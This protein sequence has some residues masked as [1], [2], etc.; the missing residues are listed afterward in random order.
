MTDTSW[1]R[2]REIAESALSLAPEE[3]DAFLSRSCGD[4]GE[5]RARVASLLVLDREAGEF[6]EAPAFEDLEPELLEALHE[7]PL[8]IGSE[9]ASYRI[10]NTLGR[11]G[12]GAVFLAEPTHGQL[13][14]RVAIKVLRS[15]FVSSGGYRR[16]LAERQILAR[17]QHPNIARLYGGGT[18][19]AGYP[20]LVMEYVD[21]S[22]IDE[23]CRRHRL[24]LEA[25]L[26]LFATLCSA[27][28]HAHRHFVVHRDLKPSNILVTKQG[29]LKLLDFGIAKPI[30]PGGDGDHYQT[31]TGNLPMTVP[32]A[33]PE[34]IRG[35]AIT[36]A[37]DVHGLGV[38]LYQLLTG[39]LPYAV[40]GMPHEIAQAV[41]SQRPQAP[42]RALARLRAGDSNAGGAGIGGTTGPWS[43]ARDLDTILLKAL[44]KQ[45][46]NRYA[47]VDRLAE[48]LDRYRCQLP[49]RARP[50]SFG[51]R[52]RRLLARHRQASAL[53]AATAIPIAA[54]VMALVR[55]SRVATAA[56]TR[57]RV[58]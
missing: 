28:Q 48:D 20:Y 15:P 13:D 57:P 9:L 39:S 44:E 2:A 31:T 38:V 45:P 35:E 11:G 51:C 7:E 10:V 33:S 42:S 14:H 1:L 22:P 37:T 30:G 52:L 23:H 41:C 19:A 54:L 40:A 50:P 47:S 36:T 29:E 3:Q 12:T 46:Q 27:V 53:V 8:G 43:N 21:G 49:I 34:Q 6:L 4:Q 17:L 16:L 5:L 24:P 26:E 18:T 32:Y 55:Q 58:A 56:A 25:R